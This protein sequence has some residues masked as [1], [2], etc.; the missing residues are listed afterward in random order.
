MNRG[1]IYESPI[2][3]LHG[4]GTVPVR[5]RFA[6]EEERRAALLEPIGSPLRNR[7]DLTPEERIVDLEAQIV[8]LQI[9]GEHFRRLK[10]SHDEI[11]LFLRDH[12]AAEI[13][14]NEPQHVAEVSTAVRFYLRRERKL[15]RWARWF[16]DTFL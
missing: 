7:P 8:A 14:R 16:V 12:Y 9:H 10:E 11:A 4:D 2:G 6:T 15:P 13:E 3:P 5:G 1:G